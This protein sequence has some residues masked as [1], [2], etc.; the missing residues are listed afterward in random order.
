MCQ[1]MGVLLAGRFQV[2]RPAPREPCVAV[3]ISSGSGAARTPTNSKKVDRP[4]AAGGAGLGLPTARR[5]IEP[6]D[7]RIDVH[8]EP[9]KGSDFVVVLPAP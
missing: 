7:G 2:S 5:L 3:T 1:I 4:R 8:T 9:G 6:Q